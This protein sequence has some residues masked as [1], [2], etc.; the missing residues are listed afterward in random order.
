MNSLV[1]KSYRSIS[2]QVDRQN[3]LNS[4][5]SGLNIT[6]NSKNIFSKKTHV[7]DVKIWVSD[8]TGTHIS[9]YLLK[10]NGLVELTIHKR[11]SFYAT[12]TI[13]NQNGQK[14]FQSPEI[15]RNI[16]RDPIIQIII[17]EFGMG[18]V[19]YFRSN[20]MSKKKEDIKKLVSKLLLEENMSV[21]VDYTAGI[22]KHMKI[23]I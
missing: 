11:K 1:A 12:L 7:K 9:M 22:N 16:L 3:A 15:K 19:E 18:M 20:P 6:E 23:K 14:I 13:F 4:L 21:D 2:K 17:M 8:A 10:Q 5:F